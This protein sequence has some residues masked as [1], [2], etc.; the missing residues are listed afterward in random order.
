ME[1]DYMVTILLLFTRYLQ[2]R[3]NQSASIPDMQYQ[4]LLKTHQSYFSDLP[5][6]FYRSSDFNFVNQY[7]W[8]HV[9]HTELLVENNH[10]VIRK[11]DEHRFRFY[12]YGNVNQGVESI[13]KMSLWKPKHI[14]LLSSQFSILGK[15]YHTIKDEDQCEYIYEYQKIRGFQGQQLQKKRNHLN[16]FQKNFSFRVEPNIDV[17]LYQKDIL[18]LFSNDEEREAFLEYLSCPVKPSFLL[19]LA[20]W[21]DNKVV[22]F[23]LGNIIHDTCIIHFERARKE[24]R[25][26][27]QAVFYYLL[28]ALQDKKIVW[29]NRE[30]DLGLEH[31][32]IAKKSYYPDHCIEKYKILLD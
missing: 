32:R 24:I 6:P 3:Y 16:Y 20:I 13:R 23:T 28:E 12:I 27:Y 18:P 5:E 29:I 22:A 21:I 17:T 15:R 10:F 11:E 30:Q 25:G 1:T 7:I 31:L 14:Y 4:P 2:V 19:P 8:R 26:S 9:A